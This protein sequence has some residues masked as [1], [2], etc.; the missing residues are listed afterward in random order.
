[1]ILTS[2]FASTHDACFAKS[3]KFHA[4][5]TTHG[6]AAAPPSNSAPTPSCLMPCKRHIM[7]AVE[8]MGGHVC[9]EWCATTGLRAAQN[10]FVV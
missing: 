5:A 9:Y 1:M 4:P 6:S 3:P 7:P 10:A 8:R 2:T